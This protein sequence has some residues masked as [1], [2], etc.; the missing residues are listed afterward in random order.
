MPVLQETSAGNTDELLC[1]C[2]RMVFL[3]KEADIEDRGRN[4]L[5]FFFP[6]TD[7]SPWRIWYCGIYD[8]WTTPHNAL[9]SFICLYFQAEVF[10]D[11]FPRYR[12][13][14]KNITQIFLQKHLEFN[15]QKNVRRE[16]IFPLVCF[17]LVPVW[18][19]SDNLH[20][21]RNYSMGRLKNL[22][23]VDWF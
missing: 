6:L 1:V 8:F 14:V 19:V 18:S 9:F 15:S 16:N 11:S 4:S 22:L 17:V 13:I 5:I 2:V 20:D 7:D 3:G 21:P 12:Y 23:P 10:P